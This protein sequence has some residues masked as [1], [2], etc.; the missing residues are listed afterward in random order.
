MRTAFIAALLLAPL[1]AAPVRAADAPARLTLDEAIRSAVQNNL[2]AKLAAAETEA[3]RARV[4]DAA[5]ALLPSALGYVSQTRVFKTN[6]AAEGFLPGTL[7]S[8]NPLLGPYDAFD[9]RV[10]LSEQIF[11]LSAIDRTRAAKAGSRLAVLREQ[12]ARE[13]VSAAAALDYLNALRAQ[14]AVATAQ[15]DLDLA[16]RLRVL[17]EDQKRA[18]AA[19]GLDVARAQSRESAQ[20]LRL[21]EAQVSDRDADLRLKRVTGLP[22]G[23]ALVLADPLKPAQLE[24]PESEPAV[25]QALQRRVEAAAAREAAEEA[26]LLANAARAAHVPTLT[27]NGD[28]GVLGNTPESNSHMTGSIGGRV[29]LPLFQGG[30]I[31]AREQEARAAQTAEQARLADELAQIEEDVRNSLQ[32]ASAAQDE[33]NVASEGLALARRELSLAQ[34]R[35]AAGVGSNVELTEAQDGLARAENDE[36]AALVDANAARVN[37]AM[38]LGLMSDFKY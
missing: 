17:A 8:I 15:A 9:A 24:L 18:G 1:L 35:F 2:S 6:L 19:T 26:R 22:L 23:A 31:R 10:V 12:L 33:Q 34:D 7:G 21:L 38:A 4:L 28:G 20:K 14:R 37:M 29:Q 3:A 32:Q 27:L 16:Q 13:Q 30:Q 5:G 25:T 11:D 36:T